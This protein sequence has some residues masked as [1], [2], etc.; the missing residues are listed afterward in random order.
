M[1]CE[2]LRVYVS[3]RVPRSD[4]NLAIKEWRDGNYGEHGIGGGRRAT[5]PRR[6]I[7]SREI[8]TFTRIVSCSN[9]FETAIFRNVSY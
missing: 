8:E 5:R 3:L 7:E 9:F 1:G 6:R 4:G 2:W